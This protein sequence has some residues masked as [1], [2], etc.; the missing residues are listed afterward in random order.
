MEEKPKIPCKKAYYLQVNNKAVSLGL[1]I[2][3]LNH[4][5]E[6]SRGDIRVA[7]ISAPSTGAYITINFAHDGR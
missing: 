4:R 6:K 1:I 5:A 3:G 7:Y 2:F